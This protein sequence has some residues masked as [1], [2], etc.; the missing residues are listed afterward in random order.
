[1]IYKL[2]LLLILNHSLLIR[3]KKYFFIFIRLFIS[4][5]DNNKEHENITVPIVYFTMP[6][7]QNSTNNRQIEEIINCGSNILYILS[8]IIILYLTRHITIFC[9]IYKIKHLTKGYKY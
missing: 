9:N 4:L 3:F 8:D 2:L 6:D 5:Y 1:M 7:I